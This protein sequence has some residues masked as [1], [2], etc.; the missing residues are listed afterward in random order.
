[1]KKVLLILIVTMLI[2]GVCVLSACGGGV[3]AQ[4]AVGNYAPWLSG[5]D[6]TETTVYDVVTVADDG[7]SYHGTYTVN[8]RRAISADVVVGEET[9]TAY[10]GY[11]V[12]SN[13]QMDNGD[14]VR[15]QATFGT[16]MAVLQTYM[17]RK[18][19]LAG[20][21]NIVTMTGKD[22]DGVFS[23]TYRET[24]E[25]GTVVSENNATIK[26]KSFQEAPYV[27]NTTLY[28]LV[29][30]LTS[31]TASSM[32]LDVFQYQNGAT[33]NARMGI[34]STT[35]IDVPLMDNEIEESR[36]KVACIPYSIAPTATFPGKGSAIAVYIAKDP[37]NGVIR[38]ICQFVED[39][40]TYSMVSTSTRKTA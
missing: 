19:S 11:Y 30:C 6:T 10:S 31:D 25:D 27:D 4:R 35:T 12:D 15:T 16:D 9:V 17:T 8:I 28:M 1:M 20:N 33:T 32:T 14:Y 38:P 3:P 26:H 18:D 34:A 23:T 37:Y 39:K 29:R 40:T 24:K 21:G 22:A 5:D 2:A 13:L 36:T 7:T